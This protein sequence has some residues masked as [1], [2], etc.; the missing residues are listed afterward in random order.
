MT[1]ISN[2]VGP[3]VI[4]AGAGTG[5]TRSIVEKLR[6]II[7]NKIY[8]IERVVCLTFSNEA[9]N[10]LIQRILPHLRDKEPI[11]KTFH[12][13]CA[14]LLRK[15][16]EKIDIRPNFKIMLPDDGKI[17]L[18]KYFKI[19]AYLCNKYIEEISIKKDLGIT[20]ENYALYKRN[21]EEIEFL[22]KSLEDLKFKINT[23]H[24]SKISKQELDKFKL[25][26]EK[27]ESELEKGK[28]YAA[29]NSYEKIKSNKNGLDYTDLHQKALELLQRHPTIAEEF[30]YVIVDEFQDTNKIQC[31]L[32]DKIARKRNITIVGDLN[33]SIYGFRG[34]Y[35]ENFNYFKEIMGV[36]DG[37]I[38]NLDKSYRSTNKI[39][40]IAHELIKN[41]YVI[42]EQCFE[43]KSAY[44]QAGE[45][46]K[47]YELKNSKEEVRK[48]TE[49]IKEELK[50]GTPIKDMCVVFRTH[51]Q[52]NT[53][54]K[55]LEYES[56]P[57]TS[58]NKD[59]LLK[60][61][62]IKKVRAYLVVLDKLANK[63]KGGD[64]AWWEIVNSSLNK[65][66]AVI[67]SQ[68]IRKLRDEECISAKFMES[69]IPGLS[70]EGEVKLES[71][72]KN[73]N[74]L[75]KE[76]LP[77][78]KELVKKLYETLNL[79]SE[80]NAEDNS[81]LA[82]EKFYSFVSDYS[83]LEST[84]LQSLIYHLTTMDS[85]EIMIE[86]PVLIKDGIRIMT[87]HATKGLEYE[88]VI[89]SSMVQKKFPIEKTSKQEE[90][91]IEKQIMEER[92]LCYVGFTRAKKRLYLTYAKEYGARQF[93]ASQFLKEINYQ[94]NENIDFI[95]DEE[96]LYQPPKEEIKSE[97][98]NIEDYELSFSP[99]ALQTFDECQKRYEM[100]YIY[101][102]PDA[103][104]QSWEAI[105]LGT[106]IHRV[107]E[108][109]VENNTKTIKEIE[110]TAK[111]IQLNEYKDLNLEGAMPMIRVFFERNKSKY[112]E[113][114]MTEKH[115]EVKLDGVLFKGFADRLDI[116]DNG[117]IT[118]VDYKTG[119]SEIK[120][121]YRNWQLGI[122]ALGSKKYG[123][124][125]RLILDT[126][127][128]EHP[129]EFE[130]DNYG[131]AKE[132]HSP[133]TIFDL[134]EV[135]NEIVTVAKSILKA[136][137]TGFKPCAP[138]KNCQFC[139]EWGK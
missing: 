33:Q 109:V 45:N 84:D 62:I 10:T 107:L 34:A 42:K 73:V 106:F 38:F 81:F 25:E 69:T 117:E 125:K 79:K 139:Q 93:E 132:I 39:L 40:A 56:I 9:V 92:R 1:Y 121:R 95:K 135:K 103:S 15:H 122:Y 22:A 71:L 41:N 111:I 64:S 86:S 105:A 97:E 77:S 100:K 90:A 27:L 4:L 11:I 58:V 83:A 118:I 2:V 98:H 18:H 21:P 61:P 8:P 19:N 35:D 55:H 123:T 50:A 78:A 87:N 70:K 85:L 23:A 14:D 89:M 32:L 3:C 13:F 28:F 37:D 59:N 134:N 116:N 126:L 137:Q 104:P 110:D 138:E 20:L 124:P 136:R 129:L 60:M 74:S 7:N 99:S 91:T 30:D 6:H 75:L 114:S 102:M 68:A 54:K 31:M 5:K 115:L 72:K 36:K 130:L 82:L 101:N 51:Q 119:K 67:A 17:L 16:G 108:N 88:T 76:S 80:E 127:Q 49:I 12:S 113:N 63:S 24:M 43:V 120:P 94:N 65:N 128:K 46:I 57:Y 133:R 112:N 48:I 131:I 29:W 53:L 66:D 52:S 96:E 47:T 26:K 44:D